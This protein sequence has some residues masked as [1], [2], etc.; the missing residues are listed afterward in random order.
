MAK[1]PPH[2]DQC[3]R[4]CKITIGRKSVVLYAPCF[5]SH[6]WEIEIE[7]SDIY[8]VKTLSLCEIV[9]TNN[10]CYYIFLGLPM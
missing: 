9:S 7:Y 2:M 6:Q 5:V 4:N 10:F 3:T 1:P 8:Y